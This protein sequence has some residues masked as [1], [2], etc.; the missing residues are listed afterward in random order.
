MK[1]FNTITETEEKEVL[2]KFKEYGVGIDMGR[3]TTTSNGLDNTAKWADLIDSK[4]YS[5][6]A[7]KNKMIEL[8]HKINTTCND[9][10]LGDLTI[11]FTVRD[12]KKKV[13]KFSYLELY[14][15]L[16]AAYKFRKESAEYE[17]KAKRLQELNKFIDENTS[18]EDKLKK[19]IAEAELL[20]KEVE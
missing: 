15:F 7:I 14:I 3:F 18:T 1:D 17:T 8:A 13:I 20:Q 9:E 19:A 10:I 6:Q 2:A 12:F 11:A 16:R 4:V 5:T